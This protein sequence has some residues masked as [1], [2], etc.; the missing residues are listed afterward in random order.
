MITQKKIPPKI[1]TSTKLHFGCGEKILPGYVNVDIVALP[2]VDV[3]HDL[4]TFPYPFPNNHFEEVYAD[5]VLEHLQDTIRIM[6]ELHRIMKPSGII[7]IKVPHFTSHDAWAHPQHTRPFAVDSFDF[8]VKGTPRYTADGRCFCFAFSKI[9]KRKL[10]FEK[11]LHPLNWHNYLVEF[12][13]NFFPEWYEKT[14]LRIFPA[15]SIEVVIK[16]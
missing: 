5:N 10:I 13:A 6:Q 8:F 14:I 9:R 11:G 16:K 4:N 1:P 12:I 2:G 3:V 7:F 15:S